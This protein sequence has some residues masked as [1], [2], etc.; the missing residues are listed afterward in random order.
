LLLQLAHEIYKSFNSLK[1]QKNALAVGYCCRGIKL[2]GYGAFFLAGCRMVPLQPP[3][4]QP[5]PPVTEAGLDV[6]ANAD[7][8]TE[9][10]N[11]QPV[12]FLLQSC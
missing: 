3:P 5:V 12:L 6:P 4:P 7:P 8:A 10:L 2:K 9:K 1:R 11:L